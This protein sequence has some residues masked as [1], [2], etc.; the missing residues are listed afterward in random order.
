[1]HS[2]GTQ[3]AVRTALALAFGLAVVA[4][5][6]PHLVD[7]DAWKRDLV[8]A[9]IRSPDMTTLREFAEGVSKDDSDA[10]EMLVAMTADGANAD[11]SMELMRLS[12]KHVCPNRLPDLDDAKKSVQDNG[13]AVDEACSTDPALRTDKQRFLA[14]AMGCD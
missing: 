8:A 11:Q 2:G 3:R 9:G 14:D 7:T 12:I 6:S 13:R 10:L 4:C 5:T 1:M